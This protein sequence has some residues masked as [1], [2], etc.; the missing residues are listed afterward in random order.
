[1]EVFT[2]FEFCG[3]NKYMVYFNQLEKDLKVIYLQIKKSNTATI[4]ITVILAMQTNNYWH[5]H[6][7]IPICKDTHIN[8]SNNCVE[9]N[10]A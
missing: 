2:W 9:N 1:M 8:K 6:T 7:Y 4:T 10:G 5:M 3:R